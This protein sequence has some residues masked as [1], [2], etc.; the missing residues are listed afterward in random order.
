MLVS[1]NL[2][3]Q[4]LPLVFIIGGAITG[5]CGFIIYASNTRV[6]VGFN[7][8]NP[9]ISDSMD[10]MNPSVNKIRVLN[11]KY[12]PMPELAAALDVVRKN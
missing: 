10:M 8:S 12:E 6:D 9:Q 7:R 4:V 3:L 2:F 5:L 1:T 11:Q